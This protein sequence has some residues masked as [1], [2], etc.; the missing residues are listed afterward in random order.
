MKA[1]YAIFLKTEEAIEVEFPDLDGCFT[2]ADTM[3]EAYDLAMEALAEFLETSEPGL[4]KDPSSYE[5]IMANVEVNK[6]A[7]LMKV[8]V[9]KTLCL[10]HEQKIRVNVSFPV[11]V[12]DKIDVAAKK[13]GRNRSH[14]LME[15]ALKVIDEM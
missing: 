9:D 2:F 13:L 15:S 1:Y 8:P 11:S 3:D 12:L 4:T 14:F 5:E 6:S 10:K 7:I